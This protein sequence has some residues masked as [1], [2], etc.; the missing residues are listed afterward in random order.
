MANGWGGGRPGAGR[1]P[2]SKH[3]RG[4]DGGADR[5]RPAPQSAAATIAV[6]EFDAPN[7]LT[8]EQRLVWLELAPHAFAAR[9][10]TNGTMAA[11]VML[12]RNV[13]I[14]RQLAAGALAGTSDHR[15]MIQR[16][17]A[18]MARFCLAPFGKAIFEA[19]GGTGE[20]TPPNPLSRFTARKRA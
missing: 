10:L 12:C 1:K 6:D 17:D 19:D 14:E 5:R 2:K 18:E 4:L 11:F 8:T 3:L 20:K 9:T 7:S 15:G 16:V 13:V